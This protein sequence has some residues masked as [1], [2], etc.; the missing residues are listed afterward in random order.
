[1]SSKRQQT[2]AKLTRERTV[3][4][5]RERKQERKRERK[6]AAAAERELAANPVVA[7]DDDAD[8]ATAGEATAG[9]AIEEAPGL[10]AA[11]EQGA[12]TGPS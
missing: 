2:M 7:A 5:K 4:E 6:L 10:D 11:E 3:R 1:M 12:P 9:E 8:E